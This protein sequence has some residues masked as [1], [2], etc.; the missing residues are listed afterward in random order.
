YIVDSRINPDD[1]QALFGPSA[2]L[3]S[4][5]V[6]SVNQTQPSEDEWEQSVRRTVAGLIR[7]DTLELVQSGGPFGRD[8][9]VFLSRQ[10]PAFEF[11]TGQMTLIETINVRRQL[12]DE[13][14]PWTE[15]LATL[16]DVSQEELF[17]QD[18]LLPQ[19]GRRAEAN[20][21]SLTDLEKTACQ[22]IVGF[23]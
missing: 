8:G 1:W 18:R 20:F 16:F 22:Y 15:G 7:E 13:C 3:V 9:Q 5:E 10:R 2:P 12:W 21:M 19:D 6:P 23:G 4:L 14:R 11:V 17:L